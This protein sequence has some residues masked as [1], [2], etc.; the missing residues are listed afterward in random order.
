MDEIL[1]EIAS[2][3]GVLGAFVCDSAG[4][5]LAIHP[6]SLRGSPGHADV[7]RIAA[8]AL[9]G[10]ATLGNGLA[11]EI[12]ISF[13]KGRVILR[14]AGP[15]ASLCTICQPSINALMLK[16]RTA[17]AVKAVATALESRI[18]EVPKADLNESVRKAIE[19][20]MGSRSEKPL[21]LVAA[22]G[23]SPDQLAIASAEAVRFAKLFLGKDKAEELARRLRVL[24]GRNI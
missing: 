24:I 7:G 19:A 13:E 22:A 14:S 2:L 23:K 10:L 20:V 21:A 3:P 4:T 18:R 12:D 16:L 1:R 17:S 8:R 15:D 5:V 6:E 11:D 9:T